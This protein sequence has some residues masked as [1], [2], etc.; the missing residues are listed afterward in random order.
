MMISDNWAELLQPGLKAIFDA[1]KRQFKDYI[2]MLFNADTSTKAFEQFLGV[3]ELGLMDEWESS[4]KQVSYEDFAKGFKA[5]FTHKKYSKGITVERELVDDDQ[6]GEIKK[7]VKKLSRVAFMTRQ[8]HAA[9]VFN[10]AFSN[11]YAGPDS[12]S[13]CNAAHPKMPGSSD[14]IR[15]FSAYEL[16]APNVELVRT[17]AAGWKDDKNNLV[18][19]IFDTLVVPPAL[20][21]TAQI[22]AETDEEPETTEHGINVWKGQLK[23]IEYPFLTDPTAWFMIDS[24]RGKEELLW[25]DRRKPDFADKVEFDDEVAKYKAVGR[26]SYG[27]LTPLFIYGCKP[28]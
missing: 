10:N 13:L 15:N 1:H 22:I 21:K 6:Y 24:A 8:I 19:T 9:S 28:A 20:R 14:T 25:F 27:W 23:V 7:R 2:P 17:N 16:N 4:G 3:G 26:W 11:G 12:V 18:L 5:L